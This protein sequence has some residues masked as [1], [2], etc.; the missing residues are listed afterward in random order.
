MLSQLPIKKIW[1][2]QFG[3]LMSSQDED[4]IIQNVL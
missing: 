1:I 2:V 3:F 4:E